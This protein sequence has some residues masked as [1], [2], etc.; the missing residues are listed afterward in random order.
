M[1]V[2]S[3][4]PETLIQLFYDCI[5]VD[6]LCNDVFDW[7]LARFPTNI[8]SNNFHALFGFHAQYFNY[9]LINLMLLS[10]RFLI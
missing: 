7:I 8:L 10:A 2:L 6:A 4:E 9:Q 1:H 5:I 3:K